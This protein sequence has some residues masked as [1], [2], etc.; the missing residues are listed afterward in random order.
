MTRVEETRLPGVGVRYAFATETGQRLGVIVHR[1]G[2]RELL[3]YDRRDPDACAAAL[4]LDEDARTLVD[5]LGGSE[6]TERLDE[7]LSQSIE[8][9]TLE[10]VEIPDA[11]PSAGARIADLG[12][13]ATTG[14][15]IVA[16]VRDGRTTTSPT[17]DFVLL[18]GDTVVLV[19]SRDA[20]DRAAQILRRG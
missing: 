7:V 10:W 4:G 5:L 14:A 1:D 15:S 19:G 17:S 6:V 13:R 18:G 2:H 9:L 11:S 3:V 16:V 8:G 12:I 20:I